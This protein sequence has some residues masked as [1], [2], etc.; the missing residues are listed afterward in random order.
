MA[1]PPAARRKRLSAGGRR[2][3]KGSSLAQLGQYSSPAHAVVKTMVN[4]ALMLD[5]PSMLLCAA[6]LAQRSRTHDQSK[7]IRAGWDPGGTLEPVFAKRK[8]PEPK[9]RPS[10]NREASRLGDVRV[11]RPSSRALVPETCRDHSI[12]SPARW[13]F[14]RSS[15]S[16][17]FFWLICKNRNSLR[18]LCCVASAEP[19]FGD[20]PQ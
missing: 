12:A 17:N 5:R 4:A 16:R 8:W 2:R 11:R 18:K 3:L 19:G 20:F 15:T 10:L 13:T 6:T 14:E 7:R 9:F 1:S